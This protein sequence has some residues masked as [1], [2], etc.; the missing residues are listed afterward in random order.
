MAC[1]IPY[2]DK[3]SLSETEKDR[4]K[5]IHITIIDKAKA[6]G[7]FRGKDQL[8]ARKLG[9]GAATKVVGQLNQEYGKKVVTL[10]KVKSTGNTEQFALKVNVLPLS[11]EQQGNLAL[12]STEQDDFLEEF[13][14]IFPDR[15]E[16]QDE[17]RVNKYVERYAPIKEVTEPKVA[18]EK[19]LADEGNVEARKG[20]EVLLRN[21]DKIKAQ[22]LQ[23]HNREGE[24]GHYN[25]DTHEI[26]L[27]PTTIEDTETAR[28]T[29]IHELHHAYGIGVLEN[30]VTD[31]EKGFA[32]NVNRIFKELKEANPTSKLNGLKNE[33]EFLADLASSR[34]FR[35]SLRGTSLWSRIIRAFRRLLG[36]SDQYDKLLELYYIVLDQS[37]NLQ[38]EVGGSRVSRKETRKKEHAATKKKLDALEQVINALNQRR[39]RYAS[40][41]LGKKRQETERDIVSLQKLVTTNRNIAVIQAIIIIE[42]EMMEL[43]KGYDILEKDPA[44][45]NPDVLRNM[46]VQLS[47]YQVLESMVND[48]RR[49]PAQYLGDTSKTGEFIKQINELRAKI[50]LLTEDVKDLNRKRVAHFVSDKTGDPKKN[51]ET[52]LERT[53]VAD[54]DIS[55]W[56][57]LF[58]TARGV[59]DEFVVTVHRTLDQLYGKA[60]RDNVTEDLYRKDVRE[61]TVTYKTP[62]GANW[63]DNRVTFKSVGIVKAEEE[64]EAWLKKKGRSIDTLADKYAPI[65]V[66]ETLQQN[67]NGVR[68]ISPLSEEGRKIMSIKEGSEDYPLRQ[69]YETMV[70]GYLKSQEQIKNPVMRPGLRIPSIQRSLFEGLLSEKG[71]DKFKLFK[72]G[73]VH[74][75][76]RRSDDTDFRAVNENLEPIHYL[77]IRF[78]S[79]QDGVDGRMTTREVSLDIPSTVAIF[80]S[81]MRTRE[82]MLKVQS[83]LE[84]VKEVT[85]ERKVVKATKRLDMPGIAGW[86]SRDRSAVHDPESGI[87]ERKEGTE[88]ESY[89]MIETLLNRFLY[90]EYK[91][92]AGDVTLFGKKVNIRK[93][94]NALLKYSG[95][96]IMLGNVAIPL[97]NMIVGEF[98]MFK[99]AVGGNLI[100]LSNLKAGNAIYK[101]AALGAI[102]DLGQREKQSKYGRLYT[103]FNPLGHDRPSTSLGIDHNWMRTTI[104]HLFRSGG[105]IAEYKMSSEAV[106]AVLDRFKAIDKEGH[107]QSMYNSVEVDMNGKVK[108]LPGYT[109]KGA[110]ELSEDNINEIRDYILRVYQIANGNYSRID[111]P[112]ATET[113]VGDLVMFM[114]KWLPEGIAARYKTR[115]Y[116]ESLQQEHEGY[117]ISALAAFNGIFT[118]GEGLL[119]RML[120][121]VRVLT[122]FSA[123]NPELLLLPNELNLSEEE[124]A[125]IIKLRE[126]GIRKTLV[127]LYLIAGF[128]L[129]ILAM[130]GGD[131]DDSYLLYMLT[132]V[133]REMLTFINPVNAWDVLRSPTVVMGQ[134]KNLY[135]IIGDIGSSGWAAVSGEE[136][137]IYK[138][139]PGKG[140]Y[141]LLYDIGRQTGIDGWLYQFDALDQKTR[142]MQ[143]AGWR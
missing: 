26:V 86:L 117:Y 4:L 127:D 143:G 103:F 43:Q 81:E 73:F 113:I 3:Q 110:K 76:R 40:Q 93:G 59:A 7:A 101:D 84:L 6:S 22:I 80:M 100:S 36:Q 132:R 114:R 1:S 120:D 134:A 107:E 124:K 78:T 47:S 75:I 10:V 104:T 19:A 92:D 24:Y 98:T 39:E 96:N 138:S 13:F 102:A 79:R 35:Q 135:K 128:T 141:K 136:Q 125:G 25:L 17:W 133:R 67:S 34:E 85:G 57:R 111:S 82:G 129:A 46:G 112:G 72:E 18:L 105:D 69:Y 118:R 74:S 15:T 126:A 71:I 122:F 61:E 8:L 130:S 21:V 14:K 68:F 11:N 55:W 30:P 90:G 5:G 37:E 51:Y 91:K 32:R 116:D 41:G 28:V 31:L 87:V 108:L 142:L 140:A 54:R 60:H 106:G 20:I 66:K 9:F 45:I 63:R 56:S 44:K 123:S 16:F 115:Y 137:P 48:I 62:T 131:D 50:H 49:N 52:A 38:R 121:T 89:K 77:P 97:T 83:D 99:E 33:R 88:S 139:G 64:Y 42:R 70:L 2:I 109:Y 27:D 23:I 65:L 119:P 58:E 95:L 29:L 53:E 94:V 12:R